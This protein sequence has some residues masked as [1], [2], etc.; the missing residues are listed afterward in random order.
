MALS[1]DVQNV[2]DRIKH[3]FMKEMGKFTHLKIGNRVS[4]KNKGCQ[5]HLTGK[6]THELLRNTV[7][8]TLSS[9]PLN[10]RLETWASEMRVGSKGR[11]VIQR[12]NS[13]G[14]TGSWPKGTRF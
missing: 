1:T 3:S 2:L 11:W 4:I 6:F 10:I 7:E 13:K 14:L 5:C 8:M 9:F 12:K